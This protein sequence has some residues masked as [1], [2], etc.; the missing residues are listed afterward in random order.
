[1]G[2]AFITKEVVGQI[3]LLVA[4]KNEILAADGMNLTVDSIKVDR[5]SITNTY[6]ISI[7]VVK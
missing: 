7:R 5:L 1:M 2:G 4:I 3:A 6:S